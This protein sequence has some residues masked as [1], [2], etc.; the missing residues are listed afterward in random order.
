LNP[1]PSF[2]LSPKKVTLEVKCSNLKC[3]YKLSILLTEETTFPGISA[4][5]RKCD[6][7]LILDGITNVEPFRSI[8]VESKSQLRQLKPE[9]EAQSRS[10][11]PVEPL[12]EQNHL[13]SDSDWELVSGG[14]NIFTGFVN[15]LTP[16]FVLTQL[17]GD[18]GEKECQLSDVV[19]KWMES[20]QLIR[21]HLQETEEMIGLKRGERLSDGFPAFSG[22]EIGGPMKIFLRNALGTDGHHMLENRGWLF[23][24]GIVERLSPTT[25]RL[26][27]M[28]E[29]ILTLPNLK[30][31]LFDQEPRLE[32]QYP[33]MA[34]FIPQDVAIQFV[35]IIKQLMVDEFQWM[36][37]I[38]SHV[39]N[40]S[41]GVGSWNSNTYANTVVASSVAGHP[42]TRW[43]H[44]DNV[45][46]LYQMYLDKGYR[47]SKDKKRKPEKR[48]KD[49][50][51]FAQDR[52]L[53]HVNSTLGGLLSR[54]KELGLIYPVRMGREK[55]F[56]ITDFGQ[57][58]LSR[59]SKMQQS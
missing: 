19:N 59:Y 31:T 54:L 49:P 6:A 43:I 39:N 53:N 51:L 45:T 4:H 48:V 14:N 24:L 50:N 33:P 41:Q 25:L 9:G 5:C 18:L 22:N 56:I 12:M 29:S 32:G 8:S 1:Q 57:E 55:N 52:L 21:E 27:D 15:R 38:L 47:F 35:E 37:E 10:L 7:L 46:P 3:G 58:V 44:H 26:S 13:V 2:L 17:I 28:S 42:N 34:V 20:S 23:K 36:L 30:S 40:A 16:I 11:E